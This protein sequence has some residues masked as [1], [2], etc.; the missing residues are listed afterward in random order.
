ME[1]LNHPR[2]FHLVAVVR[3]RKGLLVLVVL[4]APVFGVPKR[5]RF[6]IALC[7]LQLAEDFS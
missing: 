6:R 3:A 5:G 2:N 1:Y 7:P 4:L